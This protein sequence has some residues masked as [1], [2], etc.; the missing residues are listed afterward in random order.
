M[1]L[2]QYLRRTAAATSREQG[3]AHWTAKRDGGRV[4]ADKQ[5][6]VEKAELGHR[7]CLVMQGEAVTLVIVNT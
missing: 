4:A 3:A 5:Q 6:G 7:L 2:E 1:R